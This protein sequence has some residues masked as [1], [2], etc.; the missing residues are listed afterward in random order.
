[1]PKKYMQ[2]PCKHRFHERCLREWMEQK[3][4]CPCCRTSIPPII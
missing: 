3:L 2:T 4:M 1:M